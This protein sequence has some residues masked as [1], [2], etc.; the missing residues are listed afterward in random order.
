MFKVC[1]SPNSDIVRTET[2]KQ[3]AAGFLRLGGSRMDE[4]EEASELRGKV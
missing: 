2:L 1:Y 4:G 3:T